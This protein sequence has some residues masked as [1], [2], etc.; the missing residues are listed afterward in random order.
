MLVVHTE[1][2]TLI[3]RRSHEEQIRRVVSELENRGW[4]DY[5]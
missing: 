5:L 2:A 3:A 4:D 1:D